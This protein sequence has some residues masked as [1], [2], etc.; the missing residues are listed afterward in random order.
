MPEEIN[1]LNPLRIS[2]ETPQSHRLPTPSAERPSFGEM[3]GNLIREVDRIQK[4]A[5]VATQKTLSGEAEDVHQVVIAMEEAQVAF[6]LLL[7]VRNKMVEAYK[8]IIRMQV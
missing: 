3:M 1:P 6:R 4:I 8:E 2:P 5:E 7:E